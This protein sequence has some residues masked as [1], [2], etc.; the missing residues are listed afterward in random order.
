MLLSGEDPAWVAKMLGHTTLKMVYE[1]YGKFIQN[2]NR[3]DGA[4][5][6]QQLEQ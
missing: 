6:L 4:L 1:R 3:R 2:R 5:Y